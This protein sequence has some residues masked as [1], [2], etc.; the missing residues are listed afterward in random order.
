MDIKTMRCLL[1][2]FQET[3]FI[4]KEM[5]L[6]GRS[7]LA[8]GLCLEN[9]TLK[10]YLF[11]E[12]SERSEYFEKLERMERKRRRGTLTRREELLA[13]LWEQQDQIFDILPEIRVKGN[14][15]ELL[16]GTGGNLDEYDEEGR[17]LL[18]NFLLY[19]VNFGF[20]EERELSQIQYHIL[21]FA[22]EYDRIPFT[23]EDLETMELLLQPRDYHVA[24]KQKMTLE[25]GAQR[26]RKQKFFCGQTGQ[27]V[28]YFINRVELI[29]IQEELC[30][31]CEELLSQ[32]RMTREQVEEYK[33]HMNNMCPQGKRLLAV[34]YEC[35]N[36][37][38]E[39]Y[40][41]AELLEKV[42]PIH[43]AASFFL[44]GKLTSGLG[45]HGKELKTALLYHPVDP[46]IKQ[47][48]LE[49]LCASVKEVRK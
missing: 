7:I 6:S 47:V 8:A 2:Q 29:D 10:L 33:K 24:V 38:L 44:A 43:G 46:E 11:A 26:G 16:S 35:D 12:G 14:S 5:N 25:I 17:I 22:G 13:Y 32:G 19:K 18:I 1:P 36:A 45:M 49:L 31:R 42:K 21:E 34:E 23:K 41:R 30:H 9:R 15:Y 27:E 20:L 48:E 4:G 3:L 39:F 28:E 37:S 40:T